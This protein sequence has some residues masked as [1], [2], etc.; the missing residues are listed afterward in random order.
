MRIALLLLLIAASSFA[1]SGLDTPRLGMMLDRDGALRPVQGVAASVTLG[2]PVL[3]DAVSFYC[4]RER[5]L[6]KTAQAIV[7]GDRSAEAPLGNAVFGDSLVY[8]F[9]TKQLARW[10]EGKIEPV[11]LASPI[12]GDVLSLRASGEDAVDFAVRRDAG[13]SILRVRISDGQVELL[14]A[15]PPATGPVMLLRDGILLATPEELI[16]RRGDGFEKRFGVPGAER[17][18]ALGENLV[19]IVTPGGIF[20]LR[21]ERGRELL[22]Q[23][24]ETAQ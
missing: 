3:R 13:I 11:L 17:M 8:F 15:F 23:L 24:P 6:V 21:V 22:F 10:N 12:E 19:Q 9:E 16:L 18:F 2:D 7:D 20:A 1:Q 4:G 5:C 14:D